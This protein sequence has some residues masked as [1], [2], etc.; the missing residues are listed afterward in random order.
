MIH[1]ESRLL[2]GDNSGARELLVIRCLGGSNRKFSGVGDLVVAVVKKAIPNAAAAKSKIV[3]ALIVNTKKPFLTE[4][5]N[6]V[7]FDANY[8]IIIKIGEKSY[9]GTRIFVPIP[10]WFD[11]LSFIG[12]KNIPYKKILS[13]A[14]ELV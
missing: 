4:E 8:A 7:S 9:L 11:K 14:P 1:N 3:T 12:D 6:Y 13:L 10:R 5:G 2:V